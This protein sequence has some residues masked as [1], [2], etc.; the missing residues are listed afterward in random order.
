MNVSEKL[1]IVETT[2]TKNNNLA[3]DQKIQLAK[4]LEQ[5]NID[6]LLLPCKEKDLSLQITKEIKNII[7]AVNTIPLQPNVNEAWEILKNAA[8]PRLRLVLTKELLKDH[9]LSSVEVKNDVINLLS[10]S[11][12]YA[13][14]LTDNIEFIIENFENLHRIFLYRIIE[15]VADAK[16][17]VVSITDNDGYTLTHEYGELFKEIIDNIPEFE[18]LTLGTVCINK[19]GISTANTLAAISNGAKQIEAN[20]FYTDSDKENANLKHILQAFVIRKDLFKL[21]TNINMDVLTPAYS[22]FKDLLI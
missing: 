20:L 13:K 18:D 21:E 1:Y 15:T 3:P 8:K 4:Q 10:D 14:T 19:M 5:L 16:V 9:D 12:T 22:L 6:V 17:K 2:L 7:L 11:V